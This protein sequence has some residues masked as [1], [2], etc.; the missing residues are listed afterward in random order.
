MNKNT[1]YLVILVILVLVSIGFTLRQH[2]RIAIK[3]ASDV[4]ERVLPGY[5][6]QFF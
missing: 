5:A 2:Q 6:D 3:E 1:A 4:I